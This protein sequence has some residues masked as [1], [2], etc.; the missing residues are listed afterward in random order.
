[1]SE[2]HFSQLVAKGSEVTVECIDINIPFEG[3]V[4]VITEQSIT[5]HS[6]P[7]KKLP[8]VFS[9]TEVKLKVLTSENK[10]IVYHGTVLSS[11]SKRWE[12]GN[13]GQWDGWEKR[14]FFR[15]KISAD[16]VV[17]RV[18]RAQPDCSTEQ[19]FP[20]ECKLLDISA[21]GI[22]FSCL[23]GDFLKGDKVT[24]SWTKNVPTSNP[25]F[26]RC[27]IMRTE[28][29]LAGN[30]YGCRFEGLSERDEDKLVHAIF[31]FQQVERK[32]KKFS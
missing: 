29:N 2:V 28:K 10:T 6:K 11:N 30:F 12:I 27:E 1:M 32:R 31:Y 18:Q 3:I 20:L 19:D 5:F 26:F 16:A 25:F 8:T 24:I 23:Y 15:Q 14:T 13:L 17:Q 7:F 4:E 22:Q 21:S 9:G